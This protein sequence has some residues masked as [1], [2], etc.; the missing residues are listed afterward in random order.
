MNTFTI[1]TIVTAPIIIAIIIYFWRSKPLTDEE[2]EQAMREI[3]KQDAL[4]KSL[5]RQRSNIKPPRD[6]NYARVP[7][8]TIPKEKKALGHIYEEE[9]RGF[10]RK[11][12]GMFFNRKKKKR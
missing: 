5:A 2:R 4:M 8:I 9:N 7:A 1:I 12:K 10:Y 3:D 11:Y 6:S